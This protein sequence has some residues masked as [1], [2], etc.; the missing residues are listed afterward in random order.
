MRV[1]TKKVVLFS[2]LSLLVSTAVCNM[3]QAASKPPMSETTAPQGGQVEPLETKKVEV[4]DASFRCIRDMKKVRGLHLDNLLGDLEGT[5]AAANAVNGGVMYPPGSVVQIVPGEAMV[6]REKGFNAATKDWEFFILDATKDGT[7]IKKRGAGD[8]VGLGG[9]CLACHAQARPEW[10]MICET[11]HGCMPIPFTKDML[12][13]IQ[14]TDPRCG[15][16]APLTPED[17]KGCADVKKLMKCVAPA[18]EDMKGCEDV[19][20]ELMEKV[21]AAG[22]QPSTPQ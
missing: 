7:K 3:S 13:C 1:N 4:T 9:N 17:M 21:K 10:D 2:V 18:P 12:S 16:P 6:K 8:V 14:K 22:N 15:A 19:K 20:K 5:L 11:G